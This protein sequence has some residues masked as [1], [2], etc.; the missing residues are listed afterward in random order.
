MH[1]SLDTR[2]TPLSG[3]VDRAHATGRATHL[4]RSTHAIVHDNSAHRRCT[5]SRATGKLGSP[6]RKLGYASGKLGSTRM[7]DRAPFRSAWNKPVT[8]LHTY[9]SP[10]TT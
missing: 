3:P 6:A 4:R 8:P 10:P 7:P 2:S 1:H 9:Y 5:S